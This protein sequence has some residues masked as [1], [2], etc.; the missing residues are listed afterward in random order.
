M[1]KIS[2]QLSDITKDQ[3]KL[4]LLT[5]IN[6]PP[7]SLDLL[8]SA[9]GFSPVSA[10]QVLQNLVEKELLEADNSKGFGFYRLP[11]SQSPKEILDSID[12]NIVSETVEKMAQYFE[13][14]LDDP[15]QRWA[16]LAHLYIV[17]G[18]PPIDPET[19]LKAA[20]VF[21][22]RD[23]I[24]TANIC[25]NCILDLLPTQCH[26]DSEKIIFIEAVIGLLSS[27]Y[28]SMPLPDQKELLDQ[29]RLYANQINATKW[30]IRLSIY[31]ARLC[32]YS[33][34]HQ[35]AAKIS[36][37]AW[38]LAEQWDQEDLKQWVALS[39]AEFLAW[40]GRH[41][42]ALERYENAIGNLEALSTDPS[43][44]R[45][46]ASL[47][48]Y[49]YIC[50]QTARGI[51]L[52]ENVRLKAG[53]LNHKKELLFST[54]L[55]SITLAETGRM[56]EAE[57]EYEILLQ[58]DPKEFRLEAYLTFT[59]FQ[60][61]M[62]FKKDDL[63][64]CLRFHNQ[65]SDM[66]ESI[67]LW[68]HALPF[69]L[70]YLEALDQAGLTPP[71]SNFN[72]LI[73]EY[74]EFPDIFMQGVALR[75]KT[76]HDLKRSKPTADHRRNLENSL[77]LLNKSGAKLQLSYTQIELARL[78]LSQQEDQ[79]AYNLLKKAWEIIA[80]V[81]ESLF[82]DDLKPIVHP[83]D[84]IDRLVQSVIE[85]GN[86][87]CT[88]RRKDQLLSKIIQV[89]MNFILA[90]KGAVFL[91]NKNKELELSASR[92][93]DSSAIKFEEFRK[94]FE[95]ITE[96]ATHGCE[97]IQNRRGESSSS[98]T[99]HSYPP[100]RIC[101]P[102]TVDKKNLGVL[103]LETG[104]YGSTFSEENLPLLRA[105]SNQFAVALDNIFAY[106][107]INDLKERLLA[108]TQLYKEDLQKELPRFGQMIGK[109]TVMR[110]VF[111]KIKQVA[112]TD[113]TVMI[114][115][116]TGV[117]K[118]LVAHSIH[119]LSKRSKG[120]FIALNTA[121][122]N[123]NLVGSELFGHEKGA[124]TDAISKRIGRFELADQGTIFLDDV[125]N[126]GL[127][128]QAKLLRVIQE[129]EFERIGGKNIIKS[130]FRLITATNRDLKT[131]ISR[132]EFRNDLFY[133]L[134]VFPIQIPSLRERKEDIPQLAHFFLQYYNRKLGKNI[135][136]IAKAQMKRLEEYSWP[137]NVRE[138]EH[139]IE[140][141]SIISTG[142]K[143]NVPDLEED[144]NLKK[145][146]TEFKT[147]KD[148]E[149]EHIIH[150]LEL[151]NF[152]VS[153]NDG[154]AQLLGL[155]RS[156]LNSKMRQLGISRRVQFL[157]KS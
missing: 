117:G 84:R 85:V 118:E 5:T 98:I 145:S 102:M 17:S 113:A 99:F 123:S 154:A 109:S 40:E 108:E 146:T 30:Q 119:N 147:L 133:R 135:T 62:H 20:Q 55:L 18:Q 41:K 36:D 103:Y 26:Q 90:E 157:P 58:Y 74:L 13:A 126:L 153:G 66:Y 96:A 77:E 6:I 51:G 42:E 142:G 75:Y 128:I 79:K 127:D 82:P 50:G 70:K 78:L 143:L 27:R 24:D 9:S 104:R 3:I 38:K 68:H 148:M 65:A 43:T 23:Q 93:I 12:P 39:T 105:L 97:L 10:L 67:G 44:L 112:E 2:Q 111:G 151:S 89:T 121:T 144:S 16:A 53:S 22:K 136:G 72:T 137:G 61:Y 92:N 47:G 87:L 57:I 11:A 131:L 45:A 138:L 107:E 19:L 56:A 33:G 60:A 52:I 91:L 122:L 115:G 88:V 14:S 8:T 81:N 59:Y 4:L 86:T 63:S 21:I 100:I 73:S 110:E 15:P 69:V 129:K 35:Q 152:K 76:Q 101:S 95:L 34:D 7:V 155:K 71:K 149:I 132:K 83:D 49:Y 141:A 94:N 139:I 130:N 80:R 124:F 140:R 116:D 25:F 46:R 37:E 31:Y 1:G 32:S 125:D 64:G 54:L 134:N 156:T 48:Y 28:K 29:A 150:A 106:E 120:P 114:T